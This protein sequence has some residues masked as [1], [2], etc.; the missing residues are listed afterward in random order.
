MRRLFLLLFA[1][2]MLTA[3]VFLTASAQRRV[4]PV[5][6]PTGQN[7]N[8]QPGDTVMRSGVVEHIDAHGHKILIDT[9]NGTEV[10][11]TLGMERKVPK[12]IYPLLHSV[13][14]GVDVWDP[15]M[16]LFGQ[17]YGLIEF[18]GEL[19]LHNRYIPVVEIG[20]GQST[21]TPA[22]QNFT[23]RVGMVPYFRIGA[24]YNFLYNSN[25]SY[26]GYAGVR[27]GYSPF[28]Y[29]IENVTLNSGYWDETQKVDF[30]ALHSDVVYLNV[31]FGIR[32]KIWGPISMGWS[33]RFKTR[34]HETR[35]PDGNPW[36]IP[37]YG[38]RNGSIAGSFSVF[39]TLPLHKAE[40]IH[41][42]KI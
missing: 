31:L 5:K 9:I 18:S 33:F 26:M 39:Y 7:Y 8:R 36:Y 16:R 30:P 24:N 28:N 23:Y 40:S 4:T 17:H 11:D 37:G 42:P 22:N 12:M 10:P 20:L 41:T 2:I 1:C 6:P 21:Y 13:S 32:V 35:N 25:P 38:T 19:N 3:G 27:I 34:L 14:V 15:V 29:H